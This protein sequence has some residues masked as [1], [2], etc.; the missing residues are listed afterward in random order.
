MTSTPKRAVLTRIEFFFYNPNHV[1]AIID[2]FTDLPVSKEMKR[3]MRRRKRGLC[4]EAGCP[5]HSKTV[6]CPEHMAKRSERDKRARAR[7]KAA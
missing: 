1:K 4:I 7:A 5:H 2:E 6:R 3:R